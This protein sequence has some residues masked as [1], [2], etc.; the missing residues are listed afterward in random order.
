MNLEFCCKPGAPLLFPCGFIGVKPECD[1]LSC[2]NIQ[3]QAC[4]AVVS[5]AIPCNKEVPV[6]LTIAGLTIY[7]KVGL[8]MQQRDL[9]DNEPLMERD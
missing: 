8:C 6:A 1:G 7:P 4:C 3:C 9:F 2:C 5:G